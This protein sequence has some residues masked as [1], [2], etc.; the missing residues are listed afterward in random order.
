MASFTGKLDSS[1]VEIQKKIKARTLKKQPGLMLGLCL[2]WREYWHMLTNA[3]AVK[4]PQY[5][6]H[7]VAFEVVKL[8]HIAAFLRSAFYPLSAQRKHDDTP[9][10]D[11]AMMLCLPK[12]IMSFDKTTKVGFSH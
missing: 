3:H 1:H 12:V 5:L 6:A 7:C 8:S 2:G 4:G 9:L 11:H 10:T